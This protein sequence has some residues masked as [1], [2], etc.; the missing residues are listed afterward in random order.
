MEI[1]ECTLETKFA[2]CLAYVSS[3]SLVFCCLFATA[4]LVFLVLKCL[5]L[6]EFCY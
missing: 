1:V 4:S 2:L 3:F 5:V 6:G